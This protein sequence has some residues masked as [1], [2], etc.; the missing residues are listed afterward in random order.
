MRKFDSA[1]VQTMRSD[2][3]LVNPFFGLRSRN[4]SSYTEPSYAVTEFARSKK[5]QS[6]R[7]MSEKSQ[8]HIFDFKKANIK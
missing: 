3:E 4:D 8:N 5:T 7:D 6:L 1:D 2:S